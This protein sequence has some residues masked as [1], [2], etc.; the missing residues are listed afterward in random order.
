MSDFEI[1][2]IVFTVLG[3]VVTLIIEIIKNTKK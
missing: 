3:I 2:M 1:L